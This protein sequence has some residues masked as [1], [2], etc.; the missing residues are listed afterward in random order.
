MIARKRVSALWIVTL[1]FSFIFHFCAG[2]FTLFPH[3][4]TRVHKHDSALHFNPL[5]STHHPPS[6]SLP[7]SHTVSTPTPSF[8]P[9]THP[10]GLRIH[11]HHPSYSSHTRNSVGK[12]CLDYCQIGGPRHLHSNSPGQSNCRWVRTSHCWQTQARNWRSITLPPR[13]AS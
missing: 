11:T 10:Q 12:V 1:T 5:Q 2:A 9:P 8:F 3:I 6:S 7:F 4:D 13:N